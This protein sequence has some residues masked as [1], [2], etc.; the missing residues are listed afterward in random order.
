VIEHIVN[1]IRDRDAAAAR[2]QEAHR[3][4]IRRCVFDHER[5]RIAAIE[6]T[7][8]LVADENLAGVIH[9]EAVPPALV[10]VTDG[11]GR[12]Q[13]ADRTARQAGG[14]TAFLDSLTDERRGGRIRQRPDFE[15]R[16]IRPNLVRP[17]F[18]D[19]RIDIEL[20]E[21]RKVAEVCDDVIGDELTADIDESGLIDIV[22]HRR[23]PTIASDSIVAREDVGVAENVLALPV[24]DQR[25]QCPRAAETVGD[26]AGISARDSERDRARLPR[27]VIGCPI[28][29][30]ALR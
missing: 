21:R 30:A 13:R 22:A 9:I 15:D 1:G 29:S 3:T 4:R 8:S 18:C 2:V 19:S 28:R 25:A 11:D 27:G 14:A 26:V 20:S 10:R 7:T 6:E 23:D 24:G 12:V 5:S 17:D 16:P